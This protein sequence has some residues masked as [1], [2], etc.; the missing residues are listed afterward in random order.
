MKGQRNDEEMGKGGAFKT[1]R[2]NTHNG[3]RLQAPQLASVQRLAECVQGAVMSGAY[4]S[5]G[6]TSDGGAIL[7][8]ILDGPDKLSTYCT[9]TSEL[10]AAMAAIAERYSEHMPQQL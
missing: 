3:P 9:T 8:R 1:E 5:F 2:A 6:R 7:I 10:D 4:I